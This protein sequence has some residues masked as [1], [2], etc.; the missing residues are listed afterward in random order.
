MSRLEL[1]KRP[2]SGFFPGNIAGAKR[3]GV[4][5][6]AAALSP[7]SLLAAILVWGAIP[8]SKLAGKKAAASCRTPRSQLNGYRPQSRTVSYIASTFSMGKRACTL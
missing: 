7:A 6:L 2:C 4:R 5:Q 1:F 3:F 8:A